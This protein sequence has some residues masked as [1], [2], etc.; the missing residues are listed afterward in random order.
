MKLKLI[1][2]LSFWLLIFTIAC[3]SDDFSFGEPSADLKFSQDTLF[4]DTVYQQVRSE[5]Y[6]V[7]VFNTEDRDVLIPR[8]ALAGGPSSPYKINVDGKAGTSFSN[9]PLRRKDS[10]FIFVEIA[11]VATAREA[12]AEDQIIFGAGR[13]HVTLY[14]VV[15]DADF[16]IESAKNPNVIKQNTTWSAD[17]AKIIF[18]K[19]TVA[20]GQTL[21]I[22]AGTKV[23]FTK[24]S[25]LKI[26]KNAVLKISGDLGNEVILRGDRNDPRYDT[27]PLN[28]KGIVA[29]EGA[30]L[31]I[32]YAKIF[33]GETGI[34]MQAAKADI[35][36]TQIHTFQEYGIQAVASVLNAGNL[37]VNNCGRAGLGIFKGGTVDLTHTTLANFSLNNAL[38]GYSLYA[39]NEWKNA[40]GAMEQGPLQLNVKNSVLYGNRDT[41]VALKMNAAQ[42]LAYFFDAVLMKHGTDAGF[43]FESNPQIINSVKNQNPKFLN[44]S[45]AKMNL[46]VSNDSPAKGKGNS[47]YAQKLPLDIVK[48][49]RSNGPTL[50]AYQ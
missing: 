34:F 10:L 1:L 27:I 26:E 9:V 13:Q 17:K 21:N 12:I 11:P 29:E 18:G 35:T 48:I 49:P 39:T 38:P 23:Y 7:K 42:T 3:K 4:L 43:S 8:I 33:G 44:T 36:N 31:N 20:E 45:A 19:L 37:A 46:R 16:F 25:S 30:Y 24:N 40:S 6:L 2:A 41:A 22:N 47:T 50:G 5:T 32:N 14:S 15:Q 28:W